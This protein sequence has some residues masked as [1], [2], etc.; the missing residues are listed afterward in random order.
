MSPI[1]MSAS[2]IR[3]GITRPISFSRMNV[4]IAENRITQTPA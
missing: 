2:L 3:S 1:S 4:P